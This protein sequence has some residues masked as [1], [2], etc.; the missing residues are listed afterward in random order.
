MSASLIASQLD[1]AANQWLRER[2]VDHQVLDLP[3]GQPNLDVP[4]DVL[5]L[6]PLNVRGQ[7]VDEVPVGWPWGLRW[8][9]L[10]SSGIDFYP[11]WVFHGPPVTSGRGANAEQVA[12]FA[13]ALIFAAAKQ[14]PGL[15]VKD[16]AW[17]LSPL[18][19]VRGRTL[20]ILGFGSIGQSLAHKAVA[21]GMQVLALSRPGQAIA[22]QPGVTRAETLQQLFAGS[23]HLVLAAPLTPATRGLIDRQVLSHARPGLHLINIAR[24]GLLDQQ[25]LLEA[26]DSGRIG[27]ASL[28]VSEPEPLPDGHPLYH[29]PRVFL[30]PHTSAI[31]TDGYPAFLE[32]FIDNFHRYREQAPLANLVDTRRGY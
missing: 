10:V 28:D 7:R 9:Q 23:D 30:S 12:E 8:V 24:G 18:S 31:S 16:A 19:P 29:H 4:A 11:D 5:I 15:W 6:R 14:L 26:L 27:R 3:L 20:G 22:E 1:A 17:Q 25:A 21:L 13:L 32:A 2:L